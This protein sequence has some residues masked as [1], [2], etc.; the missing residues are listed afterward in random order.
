M[1]NEEK[2]LRRTWKQEGKR[3]RKIG[4]DEEGEECGWVSIRTRGDG[5]LYASRPVDRT[6][7]SSL[8]DWF[9]EM[10]R[11]LCVSRSACSTSPAVG[12]S[13]DTLVRLVSGMSM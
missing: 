9:V 5:F 6:C 10:S 2:E 1:K 11:Q 3:R 4:D 7:I 13:V 8:V 12:A